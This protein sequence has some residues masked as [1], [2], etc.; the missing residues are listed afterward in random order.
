MI[1]EALT[2]ILG[3]RTDPDLKKSLIHLFIEEDAVQNVSNII[4]HNYGE[5]VYV[6]S[7][8]IEVDEKMS[9]GEITVLSR[10]LI[11]KA[12]EL[13]VTIT[14]IGVSGVS[15][16]N[17]ETDKIWDHILMT[18]LKYPS[19]LKVHSFH[20][21]FSEKVMSFN[22]VQSFDIRKQQRERKELL[23]EIEKAYPD[24]TVN[25]YTS[26]NV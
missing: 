8:D 26:L 20:I 5:N 3:G 24:M 11:K 19:I 23:S 4:L 6:G 10:K 1:I 2:K 7:A 17:P 16:G 21:N 12:K 13:N 25:I 18:A 15:L 22:I 9:A 14:S